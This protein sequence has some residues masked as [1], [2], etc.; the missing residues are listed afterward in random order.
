MT[1]LSAA[2]VRNRLILSARVII[3]DHWPPRRRP[4]WCPICRWRW[5]CEATRAAYV[6][7]NAVGRGRWVPPHDR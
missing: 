5:P 3:T 6:Y 1:D 2:Q 4:D 7:L